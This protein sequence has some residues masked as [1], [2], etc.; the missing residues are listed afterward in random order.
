MS[1]GVKAEPELKLAQEKSF[2]IS[3]KEGWTKKMS[4][5]SRKL[6]KGKEFTWTNICDIFLPPSPVPL[7]QAVPNAKVG[8]VKTAQNKLLV[9][10]F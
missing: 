10:A 1:T 7:I 5:L 8:L 6:V 2:V 3:Q 4:R 9:R